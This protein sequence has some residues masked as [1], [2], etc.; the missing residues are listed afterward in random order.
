MYQALAAAAQIV[1]TMYIPHVESVNI[2]ELYMTLTLV[3]LCAI[4]K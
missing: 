4:L 3:V 1:D 2:T